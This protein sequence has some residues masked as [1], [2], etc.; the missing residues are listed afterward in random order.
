LNAADHWAH[1]GGIYL[2]S[3]TAM[4]RELE[5][6]LMRDHPN[7]YRVLE[8]RF[9]GD[10]CFE[11]GDGWYRIINDLSAKLEAMASEP[12]VEPI[13]AI[14]VKEKLGKLCVYLRGPM[15]DKVRA[16]VAAAELE[17]GTVCEICGLSSELQHFFLGAMQTVC[18][19]CAQSRG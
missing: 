10:Q 13:T 19:D 4:N 7:I 9:G 1:D 15:P 12:G 18:D 8:P 5:A 2:A 14:H 6:A 17:S 3:G 16:L 11:C